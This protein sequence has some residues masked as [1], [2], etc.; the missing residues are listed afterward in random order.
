MPWCFSRATACA[1]PEP[2]KGLSDYQLMTGNRLMKHRGVDYSVEEDRTGL[3][4]WMIYPKI[5]QGPKVVGDA[6][7]RSREAAV[8]SAIEEINNGIERSRA[9]AARTLR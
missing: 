3:W 5:E 4:R 9:N 2:T 8:A 7:H 1:P 6:K